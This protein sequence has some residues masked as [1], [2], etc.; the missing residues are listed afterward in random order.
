MISVLQGFKKIIDNVRIRKVYVFATASLRNVQNTQEVTEAIRESTGFEV[1]VISGE[2]EGVSSFVGA[3]YNVNVDSGLMVD[4]GGGSTELVFYKERKISRAYSIP[5]GSLSLY[6]NFVSGLVPTRDEYKKIKKFVKQQLED[7]SVSET[8][9][10]LLCGVGG[11][12][13][14]ACKLCN[15]Y[16]DLPLNNRSLE[17]EQI[18]TLTRSFY[19]EEDGVARILRVVPERIHTIIP[20]MIILRTI[21]KRYGCDKIAVSEYGV[22][23]GYLIRHVIGWENGEE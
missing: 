5:I 3:A 7:I 12:N 22:R 15:D 4:I 9:E 10:V 13:R 11:T 2:E 21:A 18:K 19:D 8:P 14:A 6:A 16:F 23:E 1:N 17:I 20:G